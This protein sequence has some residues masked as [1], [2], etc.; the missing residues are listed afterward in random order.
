MINGNLSSHPHCQS[1]GPAL[2]FQQLID[3]SPSPVSE[4]V[5]KFFAC[6]AIRDKNV[7]KIMFNKDGKRSRQ[8]TNLYC[9]KSLQNAQMMEK[10]ISNVINKQCVVNNLTMYRSKMKFHR[11]VAIVVNVIA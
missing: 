11:D 4:P 10:V 1:H 9:E 5:V 3:T 2:L 7:C 6:S 8:S